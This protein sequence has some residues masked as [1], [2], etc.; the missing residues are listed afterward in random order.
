MAALPSAGTLQF[1]D[2]S[3][4]T[5][6]PYGVTVPFNNE[7]QDVWIGYDAAT[8]QLCITNYNRTTTIVCFA[9]LAALNYTIDINGVVNSSSQITMTAT[10]SVGA[11]ADYTYVWTIESASGV[12]GEAP[13]TLA[14]ALNVAVATNGGPEPIKRSTV[15]C[16]ATNTITGVVKDAYFAVACEVAAP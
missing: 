1:F 8:G 5:P 4:A 2:N 12:V 16:R 14:P 3:N 13:V 9:G 10:P 7:V 15:R 6:A 11:A